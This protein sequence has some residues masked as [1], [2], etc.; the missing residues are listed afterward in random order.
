V[1]L[2]AGTSYAVRT[3]R[4]VRQPAIRASYAFDM[5]YFA[6]PKLLM[7]VLLGVSWRILAFSRRIVS[8]SRIFPFFDPSVEIGG[9]LVM[10]TLRAES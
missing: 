9:K 2:G 10:S 8:Q 7:I 3:S 6:N 1:F 4:V 5:P